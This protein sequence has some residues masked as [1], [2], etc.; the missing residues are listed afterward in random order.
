MFLFW[1]KI[2]KIVNVVFRLVVSNVRCKH[3]IV[4]FAYLSD[5]IGK[6]IIGHFSRR[7]KL[8]RDMIIFHEGLS[9]GFVQFIVE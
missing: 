5:D 1:S 8:F 9:Q 6:G 2:N 4:T 7:I 3:D